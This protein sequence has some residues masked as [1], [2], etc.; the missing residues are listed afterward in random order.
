MNTFAGNITL[1]GNKTII[2]ELDFDYV[3][4]ISKDWNKIMYVFGDTDIETTE[5]LKNMFQELL[6]EILLYD[7]SISSE[8]DV[9]IL[10]DSYEE[11]IYELATFEWEQVDFDEILDRFAD[12]EWVISIR[13]AEKSSRFW[14]RVIKVDFVY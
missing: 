7:V 14:N 4:N 12:F 6:G 13:E 10:W 3:E 1:N 2:W 8:V 9:S 11:W 5:E